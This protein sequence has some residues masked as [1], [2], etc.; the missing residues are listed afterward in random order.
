[1]SRKTRIV[2]GTL[3]VLLVAL[4]AAALFL[5]YQIRKS[6]P[7]T[8]GTIGVPGLGAPVSVRRDAFGVPSIRAYS[9]H[10]LM[11]AAGFVQA[12]D[13]LW[14]MDMARR[15]GEGRLSELFGSGT[16]PFDRMFRIIGIRRTAEQILSRMAPGSVDR[17]RWYADGVNAYISSARGRYP[18]EFDLLGYAPEPWT[19]LHSVIVGRLI[20]WELNLSWWTD[21]T[22]GSI[23]ARI[24]LDRLLEIMP[25]YPADVP[26][27]VPSSEWRPYA[28]VALPYLRVAQAYAAARGLSGLRGGSNAW[29]VAPRRSASGAAIL[30]NDTHLQLESPS[31]WYE[32]ELEMPG[33]RVRGM[34]MAG[35]PAVIAGRND[36]I[37]WGITNVMADDADFYVEQLDSA[38]G[39][40]Y[41]YNGSWHP[42]VK[43]AEEISVRGDTAVPLQVR[44]TGHGPV[45][46]DIQT[47]LQEGRAPYVASMRWTG[48][49]VDDQFLAFTLIDRART[50]REFA[51]G[52]A[53]FAV[54]GQ[55]FVYADVRGNIG[56]W[57]GVRLPIRAGRNSLLPLPGWDPS[58]EWRGFVPFG[59]L[60]H[61]LNPPAGYIASANNRIVDESYPYHI[62]DL[63]E[64]PSRILRL[65]EAL[66]KPGDVFSVQDFERL[67]LDTYSLYARDIVPYILEAFHD[68]AGA[69]PMGGRVFE[70]LRNWHHRFDAD[71]IATSIYQEFLVRLLRNTF[72]DEMGDSLYHDWV[73]LGNVPLR[74][75]S[76]LLAEGNSP[77][78]DDVRTPAL[79]TRD[80]IVRRSLREAIAALRESYGDDPRQWGWGKLHTVALRHPFG[81]RKPLD[82]IFN[83]GPFPA[84]GGSTALVSMEYDLNAPFAVTVGPSFRQIFDMRGDYRSVLP[85]G[86]SGQVFDV[87]YDDQTQLW[88]NGAYRTGVFGAAPGGKPDVLILEPSPSQR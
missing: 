83:I 33:M 10:D 58:T 45:V 62:S 23:A 47:P 11:M 74:V 4:L 29:A 3:G 78:F 32:L 55:N 1:M 86:E 84:P 67:Q 77:W 64:P 75:M 82:R 50:P 22:Y 34:S 28:G 14:Q 30:A 18:V 69:L 8:A 36:S 43:L 73:I 49:E 15:A 56:Y 31:R 46:T 61:M 76:R 21:V 25:A 72:A 85:S 60:P 53:E 57:C 87:H 71:D 20:A 40:K 38:T 42:F 63:W 24:P 52:V 27:T 35:V 51:A 59:R 88:L 13:R 70:Y 17:L 44:L 9:E 2:A 39:T 66:G 79:E 68:S 54:P 16:V 7:V 5:R 65:D 6:F 48:N 80:D 26:P 81:L 19:P 41:L 12:Q 37:A